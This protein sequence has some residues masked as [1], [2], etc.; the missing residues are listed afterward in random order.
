MEWK[1]IPSPVPPAKTTWPDNWGQCVEGVSYV[2]DD[3]LQ[4]VDTSAAACETACIDDASCVLYTWHKGSS[5]SYAGLSCDSEA[6]CCWLK[7]SQ[8][9][10][11]PRPSVNKCACSGY[12]RVPADFASDSSTAL[13]KA[14]ARPPKKARNL[15]Y[16]IVDD[17]RSE[18][19][20]YGQSNRTH[21]TPN[22]HALSKRATLFTTA[23]AQIGV[24]APSRMSFLT[25]RRPDHLG[26]YNFINHIRQADCGLEEGA[27]VYDGVQLGTVELR[28]CGEPEQ[29]GGGGQCC[30]VCARE[31]A[32]EG[33][34][35]NASS[36]QC[37]M[38]SE[39]KGPLGFWAGDA[40]S[41]MRG[42]F[43]THPDWVPLPQRLKSHGWR[44][45]SSGKVF[46]SE[47]GGFGS[48]V[49]ED[50]GPGLPPSN[51][52]QSWSYGLSML[53]LN[54]VAP[55]IW[56]DI[57]SEGTETS[58][59]VEADADGLVLD[60]ERI[61][62]LCDRIIVDDA[63]VKLRLLVENKQKTG[64]P[65]LLAVGLRKP[66]LPYR[67]PKP[68]LDM[69]P[70]VSETDVAQH[71][72]LDAS[73]PAIAHASGCGPQY[74]PYGEVRPDISQRW[75]A[76]YRAS[77]G[78]VDALI[79]RV[80]DD[81]KAS[82]DEPNTMVVFHSDHGYALGERGSWEKMSNE[83]LTLRVPLMIAVPWMH[84]SLGR[85]SG[86]VVELL[87]IYPTVLSA[88]GVSADETLDGSSLLPMMTKPDSAGAGQN[89]T[90]ALSQFP[91][92]VDPAAD[93]EG[94]WEFNN[95]M[96][97]DR[98]M[99]SHMG[100]SIRTR[101]WRFTEWYRWN[102]ASLTPDWSDAVGTELYSHA[103]DDGSDFDAF[104][105]VNQHEDFPQ[106]ADDLRDALRFLIDNQRLSH[107]ARK[108]SRASRLKLRRANTLESSWDPASPERLI[109]SAERAARRIVGDP[110]KQHGRKGRQHR[111]RHL[112]PSQEL[113]APS[114]ELV[115]DLYET[116]RQAAGNRT[117]NSTRA[118]RK[119][120]KRNV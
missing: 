55:M 21:H 51:D 85:K 84:A 102:G 120:H 72:R 67:F 103:G 66:H 69:L 27:I 35:Y 3:M 87:D 89:G 70:P 50:N 59:A 5:C 10:G 34:T 76:Y 62:Q 115:T 90:Y 15:L 96:L 94:F 117:G 82:G 105:N 46:H 39:V 109:R 41:G 32:C 47:E 64:Q 113:V 24:C 49:P 110:L 53:Q 38:F 68:F 83:E 43:D 112:G 75:R 29:C 14:I 93:P 31:D 19:T 78:W 116:D 97:Q 65:W 52:P 13:Y 23:Y 91:R 108:S 77:V 74:N 71:W 104:E 18:L 81:L 20:A 36:A 26:A 88:L 4:M 11:S 106:V 92:C 12:S 79:G 100:Y 16:L 8:A 114:Q 99:F 30:T 33:W 2:A 28:G 57:E 80:L 56:C 1:L 119:R 111:Q 63:R 98:S 37:T 7:K 48:A 45:A 42:T 25:G 17:L 107:L 9:I 101:T 54:D 86:A 22:T 58:C 44:V 40:V 6:G 60:P 95:C 73:V 118:E 61:P